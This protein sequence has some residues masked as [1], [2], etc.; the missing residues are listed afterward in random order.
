MTRV[1]DGPIGL[2]PFAIACVS[3]VLKPVYYRSRAAHDSETCGCGMHGLIFNGV[4]ITSRLALLIY[5][6]RIVVR[7]VSAGFA[8]ENL[9][10]EMLII[11]LINKIYSLLFP[12]AK[13][14][15]FCKHFTEIHYLFQRI[16]SHFVPFFETI[17]Y[18]LEVNN[19]YKFKLF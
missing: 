4:G 5:W 9:I 3:T 12:W 14:L 19:S 11:V 7:L 13:T 17:K 18:A 2:F 6:C 16:A 10:G 1:A 15:T 8:P